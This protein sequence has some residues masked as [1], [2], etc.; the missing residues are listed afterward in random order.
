MYQ[1]W[2]NI[3]RWSLESPEFF[4]EFMWLSAQLLICVFY[5]WNEIDFRVREDERLV[6]L[7]IHQD[8]VKPLNFLECSSL[9]EV[10]VN[11][12][13]MVQLK[14]RLETPYYYFSNSD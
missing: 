1:H 3:N 9:Y 8:G 2:L 10:E 14:E 6:G 12:N 11:V 5:K 7:K 13:L 4:I